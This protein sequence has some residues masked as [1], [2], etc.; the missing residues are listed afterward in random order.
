M[1]PSN[2]QSVIL[3]AL[4]AYTADWKA[5]LFMNFVPEII[6]LSPQL[7]NAAPVF[8]PLLALLMNSESMTVR[9][10]PLE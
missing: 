7:Y 5:V 1:F 9:F 10:A 6:V 4:L 3:I 2:K 8:A